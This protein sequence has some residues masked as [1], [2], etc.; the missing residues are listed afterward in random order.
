MA[1]LIAANHVR[2]ERAKLKQAVRAGT[3]TP[4]SVLTWPP[5]CASSMK[6]LDFLCCIPKVGAVK[7][8]R[9]LATNGISESKR[10]GALSARQCRVLIDTLKARTAATTRYGVAVPPDSTFNQEYDSPVPPKTL[11]GSQRHGARGE[12]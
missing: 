10:L 8:R 6:A 3:V 1:A 9:I 12:V 7:A 4:A 5:A 2:V 11:G